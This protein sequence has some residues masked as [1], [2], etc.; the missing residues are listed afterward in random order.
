MDMRLTRSPAPRT[1]VTPKAVVVSRLLQLPSSELEPVISQELSENPALELVEA[2]CC[3][4]C[5]AVLS[6]AVCARCGQGIEEAFVRV[7]ERGYFVAESRDEDDLDPVSRI[8]APWSLRDHILWQLYPQLSPVELEIASLLLENLDRHGLL[9]CEPETIASAVDVPMADV[10]RVLAAIQRQDPVGIGARTVQ[11]SLLIQLESW[12]EEDR[13]AD[14]SKRLIEEHWEALGR[15]RLERI[16]RD[17]GAQIEDVEQA[18]DFIRRKLH[19]YPA[20]AYLQ[21]SASTEEPVEAYYLRP[22]VI[23]ALTNADCEQD[24]DIQ[25][26]DE[27]RYRLSVRSAY[28]ELLN[29]LHRKGTDANTDEYEHVRE[30]VSRSKLFISGWEE[31]WATLRQVLQA[32]VSY[33]REFLLSDVSALRPLTRARLANMLGLHESTVSRA[34][35]SKYAQMPDGR[36]VALADFFDGSLKAKALIGDLISEESHPL[37][38]GELAELLAR[39]GIVVARRTVAK[40]RQALGILPSELR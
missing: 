6:G 1:K 12:P 4:R 38:D 24:L 17:L 19:P 31:R 25:F 26:P 37:T 16:A 29:T 11:E 13:L 35:A 20:H 30:Y 27:G 3:E 28:R 22:D 2:R 21:H 33:Q 34:V 9:D 5:G 23:I 8:A 40:Y 39:E 7:G 18:K 15:G 10:L 14:L 32:L 36:I